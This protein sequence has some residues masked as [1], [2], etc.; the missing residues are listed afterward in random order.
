V[1]DWNSEASNS[2][3]KADSA[4]RYLMHSEI[5]VA[6]D[7]HSDFNA[8]THETVLH[9]N[10]ISPATLVVQGM[11]ADTVVAVGETAEIPQSVMD[12]V[13]ALGE[14]NSGGTQ[15]QPSVLSLLRSIVGV[16]IATGGMANTLIST[17][18]LA[19]SSAAIAYPTGEDRARVFFCTLGAGRFADESPEAVESFL[20]AWDSITGLAGIARAFSYP[21]RWFSN[22]LHKLVLSLPTVIGMS[23]TNPDDFRNFM[24]AFSLLDRPLARTQN[25]YLAIVPASTRKDDRIA[26]L[27]GGK[28][29][30]IVRES[31]VQWEFVGSSYVHGIMHGEAW[32]EEECRHM[33]FI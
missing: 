13:R 2:G 18:A 25:G 10:R 32:K 29:P 8:S 33:L 26:L 11:I 21:L 1:P 9:L 6:A 23:R 24:A 3:K 5:Y 28:P 19:F 22:T 7:L 4:L 17:K 30:Y 15:Q 31:G 12:L 16:L 20:R 27:A 14:G